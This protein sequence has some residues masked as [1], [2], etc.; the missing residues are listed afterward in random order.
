MPMPSYGSE[1]WTLTI[2]EMR[3]IQTAQ[4]PFL[5]AV[6]GHRMTDHK[7]NKVVREGQENNCHQYSNAI[8]QMKRLDHLER[9]HNVH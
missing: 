9:I 8:Y 7:R 5:R 6:A 4:T 1:Y 2:G 3:K